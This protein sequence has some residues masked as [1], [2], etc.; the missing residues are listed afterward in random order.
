MNLRVTKLDVESCFFS[1]LYQFVL[2]TRGR[3]HDRLA[4]VELEHSSDILFPNRNLVNVHQVGQRGGMTIE[5]HRRPEG[6]ADRLEILDLEMAIS[7]TSKHDKLEPFLLAVLFEAA[8]SQKPLDVL[9]VVCIAKAHIRLVMVN[10]SY[11]QD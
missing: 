11:Q 10:T 5:F 3:K 1:E 2:I 7:M 4:L 8:V 9:K 6:V